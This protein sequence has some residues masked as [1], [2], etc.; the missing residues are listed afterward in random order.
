[1][2]SIRPFIRQYNR[3]IV[4]IILLAILF[5]VHECIKCYI[6]KPTII[7]EPFEEEVP[8]QQKVIEAYANF[9]SHKNFLRSGKYVIKGGRNHKYCSDDPNGIICNRDF[10]GPDEMFTIVH[11]GNHKYA[12]Q[13]FRSGL[14]CSL[15]R[16]GLI[17]NAPVVG[18]WQVFHIRPLGGYTYG[19]QSVPNGKWC[20]ESGYGLVC[21][22][23]NLNRNNFQTF[24]FLP[25]RYNNIK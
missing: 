8:H 19:I 7:V 16:S 20:L 5:L 10:A 24:D 3:V 4:L 12:I 13:G 11:L 21:D 18:D 14:W 9:K 17:C 15:T 25:V 22:V 2:E 6:A 1:M 23:E